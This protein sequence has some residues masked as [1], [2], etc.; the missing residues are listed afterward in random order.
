M[1]AVIK[2][3]MICAVPKY[4]IEVYWSENGRS[5]A[6]KTGGSQH[7]YKNEQSVI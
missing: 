4:G 2:K 7:E 3:Y 6:F 1:R 5:T